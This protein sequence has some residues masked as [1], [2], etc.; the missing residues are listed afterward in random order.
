VDY[1]FQCIKCG[2]ILENGEK[3]GICE[4]CEAKENKM[5]SLLKE[6]RKFRRIDSKKD[7]HRTKKRCTKPRKEVEKN[8]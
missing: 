8:D 5:T 3:N 6:S 4:A 1:I 7:T 2:A